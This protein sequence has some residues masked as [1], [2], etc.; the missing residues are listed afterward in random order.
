MKI[1]HVYS[2]AQ[3]KLKK[4][5]LCEWNVGFINIKAGLKCTALVFYR[6]AVYI[7]RQP[8]FSDHSGH[9]D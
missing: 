3:I 7:Q 5:T 1:T 8:H 9:A 4:Y 2:N 6:R